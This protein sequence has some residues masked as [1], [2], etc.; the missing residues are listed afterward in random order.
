MYTELNSSNVLTNIIFRV[1]FISIQEYDNYTTTPAVY[2]F[3]PNRFSNSVPTRVPICIILNIIDFKFKVTG[4][5]YSFLD[6]LYFLRFGFLSPK[7][8][9][10]CL[11]YTY[12]FY[13][14]DTS[15]STHRLTVTKSVVAYINTVIESNFW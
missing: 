5:L 1:N 14:I 13:D 10:Y 15:L 8:W 11:L 3:D 7:L 4:C 12:P 9:L 6:E 2:R